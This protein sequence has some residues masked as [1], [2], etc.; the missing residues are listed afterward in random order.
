MSLAILAIPT[1]LLA[2]APD[3]TGFML[4]RIAQGLCMSTA[5][6]PTMAYLAEQSSAESTASALA[7]YITGNVA[8]NFVGRI[9]SAAVTDYL[10][11]HA[12]FYVFAALNLAGATLVYFGLK[13]TTPMPVMT[14]QW[15]RL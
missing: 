6:T 2:N 7:A 10:G 1:S 12:N 15:V 14:K 11:L 9:M 3:I 8:S 4:L 13:Q 5:F